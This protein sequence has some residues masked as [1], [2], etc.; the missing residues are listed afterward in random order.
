MYASNGRTG[1][2]AMNPSLKIVNPVSGS[3]NHHVQNGLPPSQISQQVGT[4]P[5]SN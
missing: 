4:L 5:T 1:A 3:N 2:E